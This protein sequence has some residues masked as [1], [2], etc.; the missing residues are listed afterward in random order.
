[1]VLEDILSALIILEENAKT[2]A[3]FDLN[4]WFLGRREHTDILY[5]IDTSKICPNTETN[6]K[7]ALFCAVNMLKKLSP[8]SRFLNLLLQEENSFYRSKKNFTDF[9]V[10]ILTFVRENFDVDQFLISERMF[11]W[12]LIPHEQ[13]EDVSGRHKTAELLE[14]I[15]IESFDIESFLDEYEKVAKEHILQAKDVN[16]LY[17]LT[18]DI[19]S[20]KKMSMKTLNSPHGPPTNTKNKGKKVCI[21]F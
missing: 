9:K 10:E 4:D 5:L 15:D 14:P 20:S 11:D 2:I 7:S 16:A 12:M 8:R 21:I 3:N 1:M 19:G 18:V 13:F 17:D 6:F